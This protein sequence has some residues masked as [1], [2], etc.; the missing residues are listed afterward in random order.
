MDAW[1]ITMWTACILGMI[2]AP[3]A[4]TILAD[5][6]FYAFAWCFCQVDRVLQR[7]S[8]QARVKAQDLERLGKMFDQ[9]A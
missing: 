1:I 5:A 7:R 2:A 8:W 9:A 4:I 6:L 3:V